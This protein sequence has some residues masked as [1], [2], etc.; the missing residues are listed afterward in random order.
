M[1]RRHAH[2]EVDDFRSHLH[3]VGEGQVGE[4]DVLYAGGQTRAA[5][6][7]AGTG[8]GEGAGQ[9]GMAEAGAAAGSGGLL[10]LQEPSFCP[11]PR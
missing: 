5:A 10:F 7:E 9:R 3:D 2:G 1:T 8:G 11:D 4:V 6:M